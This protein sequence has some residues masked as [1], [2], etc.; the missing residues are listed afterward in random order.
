MFVQFFFFQKSKSACLE[1]AKCDFA[2]R[3][4]GSR[5]S[6]Q[7]RV[8]SA[9]FGFVKSTLWNQVTLQ[10]YSPEQQEAQTSNC[11]SSN[12]I[13]NIRDLLERKERKKKI[14]T[15][16]LREKFNSAFSLMRNKSGIAAHTRVMQI[17]SLISTIQINHFSSYVCFRKIITREA[18]CVTISTNITIINE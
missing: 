16:I 4:R 3:G 10:R 9:F 14:A 12:V 8:I 2:R 17:N 15:A 7:A 6:S 18:N 13:V 1:Y 11:G 5:G